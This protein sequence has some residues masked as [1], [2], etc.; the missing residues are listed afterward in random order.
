MPTRRGWL[1]VIGS[2]VLGL[3]GRLLGVAE[4]LAL[5]AACVTLVAGAVVYVH[6]SRVA[7]DA[8]RLLCPGHVAAG[9]TVEVE[10]VVRN[11]ARRRTPVLTIHD[12]CPGAGRSPRFGLAPMEG[13]KQARARYRLRVAER[14]TYPVGPLVL[15]RSDPF[16]VATRTTTALPPSSLVVFPR[17][18]EVDPPPGALAEHAVAGLAGGGQP[19][20]G[21]DDFT[22]LR[23]YVEG[24]DLRLVHWAS[25]AKYDELI[26]RQDEA[27]RGRGTTV[28]LDLRHHVHRPASVEAAVSAAASVV[29]ACWRQGAPVRLVTT[30]GIDATAAHGDVVA[31]LSHLAGV[32]AGPGRQL[33][34]VVAGAVGL[35][36]DDGVVAITTDAAPIDDLKALARL[37][38]EHGPAILVRL[39]L[40]RSPGLPGDEPAASSVRDSFDLVVAVTAARP[41]PVA[42][43]QAILT[44]SG[45]P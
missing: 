23:S 12:R 41:F 20:R 6:L 27:P 11:R 8:H 10:V 13:T 33:S 28:L 38:D 44:G 32:G 19:G 24:D 16:G 1:L 14:G 17:I 21:H 39:E 29:A 22:T 40:P 31:V 36:P 25:T 5:S 45:R 7:L 42:W 9:G 15:R 2:G 34:D 18:D 3:G 37:S 30:G 26:V 35:M 43:E 4:L